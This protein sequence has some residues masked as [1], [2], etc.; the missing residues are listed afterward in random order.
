M[1]AKWQSL[2][3]YLH[4]IAMLQ[5]GHW[6]SPSFHKLVLKPRV[7]PLKLV[8]LTLK[9]M[10]FLQDVEPRSHHHPVHPSAQ[11]HHLPPVRQPHPARQRQT[12][13]CSCCSI[14]PIISKLKN[15]NMNSTFTTLQVFHGPAQRA[16]D[17]FSDIGKIKNQIWSEIWSRNQDDLNSGSS[18]VSQDTPVRLTTTPLTSSWTSST[19]TQPPSLSAAWMEKVRCLQYNRNPEWWQ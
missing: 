16:L 6:M 10:V 1:L 12:G 7:V 3:E 19:E 9:S 15:R 2:S 18:A 4:V 13:Q 11:I 17:Y 5:T 8:A 14:Q